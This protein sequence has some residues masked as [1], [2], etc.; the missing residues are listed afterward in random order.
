MGDRRGAD[1]VWWKN[2]RNRDHI[3]DQGIEGSVI[4]KWILRR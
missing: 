2:F 1:W 4:L 3:E